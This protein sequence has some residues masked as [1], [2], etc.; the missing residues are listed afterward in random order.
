MPENEANTSRAEE[1]KERIL[2][3]SL[4]SLDPAMPEAKIHRLYFQLP[5][6]INP[7]VHLYQYELCYNPKSIDWYN[8]DTSA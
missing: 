1:W 3:T 8:E 6:P 5:E 7:L 4:E 2:M